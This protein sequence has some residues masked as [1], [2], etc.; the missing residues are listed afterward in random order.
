MFIFEPRF[1]ECLSLIIG[2]KNKPYNTRKKLLLKN[3]N[4]FPEELKKFIQ[5]NF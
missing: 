3:S 1:E 5:S 2:E 4:E